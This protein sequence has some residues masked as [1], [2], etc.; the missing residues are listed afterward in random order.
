[1]DAGGVHLDPPA[2]AALAQLITGA[3]VATII[4]LAIEHYERKQQK[5]RGRGPWSK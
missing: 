1:M 5:R 3:L 2:L 4:L